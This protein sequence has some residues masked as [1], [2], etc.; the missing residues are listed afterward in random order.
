MERDTHLFAEM[1]FAIEHLHMPYDQYLRETTEESRMVHMLWFH[2]YK[3]KEHYWSLPSEKR[4]GF[5][6]A[7]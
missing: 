5:L 1:S 4:F 6:S 2:L 7:Q 3:S